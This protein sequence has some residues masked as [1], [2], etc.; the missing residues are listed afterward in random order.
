MKVVLK[1]ALSLIIA[2]ICVIPI[3][4]SA[5]ETETEVLTW[6]VPGHYE[7]TQEYINT[8]ERFHNGIDI[9]DNNVLGAPVL[10]A[11]GGTVHR[12]YTC[13]YHHD[14][15]DTP[16]YGYG[17]C[18]FINGDD[19]RSYVYAHML[20]GSIPEYVSE[21]ARV[22]AGTRIGQVGN[23]GY[24]YAAHLHFVVAEENDL[25]NGTFDPLTLTFGDHPDNATEFTAAG[26]NYPTHKESDAPFKPAGVIFSPN[27]IIYGEAQI[28]DAAGKVIS[29]VQ[30]PEGQKR[31]DL[32]RF[33]DKLDFA[34]LPDGSYRYNVYAVYEMGYCALIDNTFTVGAGE[35]A[36]ATA[37]TIR[38]MH[39]CGE[40]RVDGAYGWDEGT[41]TREP[42]CS[43]V[44]V[45]TYTCKE[46][47]KTKTEDIPT[48][49]HD[50]QEAFTVDDEAT[51]DSVGRKSRHC[52]D[53]SAVTDVTEIPMLDA[54]TLSEE[55]AVY[56]II[57]IAV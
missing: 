25:L 30:I 10:A 53:C 19:G 23:T 15:S 12:V 50:F 16:C 6:P 14:T 7:V 5:T 39:N 43:K 34:S 4:V 27:D 20:G 8:P 52:N 51:E 36:F 3:A 44:G 40:E 54:S 37:D 21:G 49:A 18:V 42:T 56:F 2:I 32:S 57:I 26:V 35:T 38:G 29:S 24:S 46:C 55:I 1:R 47:G 11:M 13:T 28:L 31:F 33:S 48:I 45:K 17:T 41:V 9:L 22:E